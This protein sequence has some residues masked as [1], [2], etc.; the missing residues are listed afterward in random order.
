EP[1]IPAAARIAP[2]EAETVLTNHR[3]GIRVVGA[4]ASARPALRAG[5]WYRSVLQPG[6][7]VSLVAPRQIDREILQ[8]DADR[9]SPLDEVEAGALVYLIAFDLEM[10][11]IDF[12]VGTDHPDVD[13][14]PRPSVAHANP[15]GPDGFD[16]V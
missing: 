13:W 1:G 7:S 12:H 16:S 15:R 6:V 14:S 11:S 3:V 4:G 9:A 8:R 2:G 5:R 10:L